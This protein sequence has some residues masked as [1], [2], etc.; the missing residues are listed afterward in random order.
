MQEDSKRKEPTLAKKLAEECGGKYTLQQTEDQM[1]QMDLV[2]GNGA[3]WN[4]CG[5]RAIW[6]RSR[7]SK[8]MPF[9]AASISK[10]PKLLFAGEVR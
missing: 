4:G 2:I 8:S 7:E 5:F 3:V 1:A 9:A 6:R 10:C